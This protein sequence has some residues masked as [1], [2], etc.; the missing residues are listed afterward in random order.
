MWPFVRASYF[1]LMLLVTTTACGSRHGARRQPAVHER[2]A[3]PLL[4]QEEIARD[5]SRTAYQTIEHLRPQYLWMNRAHASTGERVVYVD[6][7]RLGTIDALRGIASTTIREIRY[8]DAR[9]ATSR[10]GTGHSAGAIVILTKTG[11]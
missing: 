10:F 6:E 11:R 2:Y 3:G 8:L 5:G 7:V 4:T 1:I 9:E